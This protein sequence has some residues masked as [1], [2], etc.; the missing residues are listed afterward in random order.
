MAKRW[1]EE[2]RKSASDSISE[3]VVSPL[4]EKKKCKYLLLCHAARRTLVAQV[5]LEADEQDG[6]VGPA[7]APDLLVP[8]GLN[9]LERVG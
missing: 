9:V 4:Q 5:A 8:L 6:H 3:S 2:W 1:N 7:Y